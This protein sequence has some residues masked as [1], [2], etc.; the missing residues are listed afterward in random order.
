MK[1][2]TRS[3]Y[4]CR[5]LISLAKSGGDVRPVP[6][7]QIAQDQQISQDYLVQLLALLKSGGLVTSERGPGGGVRLARPASEITVADVIR[8]TEGS[9]APVACVEEPQKCDRSPRCVA[10][11]VWG[12]LR[13]AI[14]QVLSSQTIADLAS[15][16]EKRLNAQ[17]YYI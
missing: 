12:K 11:E 8:L 5:A 10:R 4:A 2:S 7:K 6:I 16:E 13:D 17:M 15:E 3:R 1:L 9:L 14:D